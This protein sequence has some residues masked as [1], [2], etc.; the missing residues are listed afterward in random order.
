MSEYDS[1]GQA[2]EIGPYYDFGDGKGPVPA[3]RHKNKGGSVH[4]VR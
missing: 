2:S 1:R 3:H 4:I